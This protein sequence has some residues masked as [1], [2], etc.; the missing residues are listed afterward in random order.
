MRGCSGRAG[1]VRQG[2]GSSGRGAF[3]G[4]GIRGL[5]R[6]MG[7]GGWGVVYSAED[8]RLGRR[9]AVKALAPELA[10]EPRRR[11]MLEHEAR[12]LASLTHPNIGAI[13]GLED[14]PHGPVLVLEHIA[15]PTL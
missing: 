7:G 14:G 12:M 13:Y 9:V 8:T 3:G 4:R 5:G 6:G 11:A 15:G 10:S 2:G 1:G